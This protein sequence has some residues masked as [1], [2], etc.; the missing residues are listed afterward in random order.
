S[1]CGHPRYAILFAARKS[2]NA[3]SNN[4][5]EFWMDLVIMHE[6]LINVYNYKDDEEGGSSGQVGFNPA[7]DQIAFLYRDGY[8]E[9]FGPYSLPQG[10]VDGCAKKSYL[11]TVVNILKGYLNNNGFLFVLTFDHSGDSSEQEYPLFSLLTQGGSAIELGDIISDFEFA[12]IMNQLTV[13]KRVFVMQQCYSGG[14]VDDL[15]SSNTV[16]L[17]DSSYMQIAWGGH[18]EKVYYHT[19]IYSLYHGEMLYHFFSALRRYFVQ[20]VVEFG[21]DGII[22]SN[23]CK[24]FLNVD[25]DG[26]NLISFKEVYSS[27]VDWLTDE[28]IYSYDPHHQGD[29]PYIQPQLDADGNGIS[30]QGRKNMGGD[31]DDDKCVEAFY[32]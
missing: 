14:F 21:S 30:Q 19:S 31:W 28:E 16:I 17:T 22:T 3:P 26:N 27:I 1:R 5:Y 6:I 9:S 4:E 24:F 10:V 7:T 12:T 29:N 8:G 2:I 15:S 20:Y 25:R 18:P 13:K 23:S 11:E 32:F